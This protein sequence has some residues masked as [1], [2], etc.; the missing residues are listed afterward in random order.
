MCL[1]L[2]ELQS[3]LCAV[4]ASEEVC[5]SGTLSGDV[6]KWSGHTL[7]AVIKRAHLV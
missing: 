3:V 1:A 7:Q 2:G 4:F 5:Y 6:Y